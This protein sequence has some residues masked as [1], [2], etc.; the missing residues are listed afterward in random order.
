MTS[1]ATE[2]IAPGSDEP[3]VVT[4]DG[5]VRTV[6]LNR[7]DDL[8]AAD[9][10]MHRRLARVWAELADDPEARAVVLTGA[11]RAFSAGGD[12]GF[13]REHRDP[14]ARWRIIEEARRIAVEMLQFPLP[15]VAA[16]NGPAVGLGCSLALMSDLVLMADT[17]FLADPHILV[18]LVPGDGGAAVLP[19][20]IGMLRAKEFLFLGDRVDA[21]RAVS[22]GMAN[23]V[24]PAAELTAR[25]L[26]LAERLAG[27]PAQA[28]RDTKR[29]LNQNLELALASTRN[30]A[31]V[32]ERY[33]MTEAEHRRFL[34]AQENR[35]GN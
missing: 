3:V 15:V 11:G 26:A 25:A 10:A 17:A 12:F 35:I 1:A 24:V 33:S 34:T 28:L 5:P 13:M 21:Q 4:A 7:P 20:H 29:A 31:L 30:Y 32:A 22:M 6:T 9:A 18:G 2:A 16:V 19:A 14:A 23:H 27:L 8:N